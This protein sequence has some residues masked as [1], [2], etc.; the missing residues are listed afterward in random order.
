M[1]TIGYMHYRKKPINLCKAYAFAAVAKAEGVKLLYFSP[2]AVDFQKHRIKGYIY[3]N[4]SWIKKVSKFPDVIYN[5]TGF[6][7]IK[8]DD[9]A[10]KLREEIPFTSNSIGSKMTVFNNLV[11]YGEF[12]DNLIPTENVLYAEQFFKFIDKHQ[13]VVFKPSFGCQGDDVYYIQ[14]IG[15]IY[16]ILLNECKNSM[17]INEATQFVDN[18]IKTQDFIIQPYI[19]SRTKLGYPYDIRL[20]AQKGFNGEWVTV[21][22]Y[23]RVS[24]TNN[25]VCNIH[26][27]GYTADPDIFFKREFGDCYDDLMG[28]I[29]NFTLNLAMHLD[30]IQ[31]ELYQEELDELGIDIGLDDNMEIRIYEINWRPGYPPSMNA[32]LSVIK[33]IIQYS[34]FLAAR[35]CKRNE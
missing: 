4:G 5:V 26:K 6:S 2:G 19:N 22:I 7:Y 18:K 32:D 14:K 25:I 12:I 1:V 23:P 8:Q 33:N 3:N 34:K 21:K 24:L 30:R 16:E 13:K 10:D 29:K 27:G 9:I 31:M 28:K 20:H 15:N 11:K 17:N 35:G